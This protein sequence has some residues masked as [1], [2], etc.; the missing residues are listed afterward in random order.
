MGVTLTL[1]LLT[2]P[3]LAAI[4]KDGDVD[5]VWGQE[6]IE[7]DNATASGIPIKFSK[8][9]GAN[10][11]GRISGIDSFK[12]DGFQITLK[13]F[14]MP[15]DNSGFVI[16]LNNA[17]GGWVDSEGIYFLNFH[18]KNTPSLG[19]LSYGYVMAK[20]GNDLG[21][22]KP[23]II[24]ETKLNAYLDDT[25]T[26]EF[27]KTSSSQWTYTVNGQSFEFSD[28]IV[29]TMIKDPDNVYFSLGVWDTETDI[30][31]TIADIHNPAK[32]DTSPGSSANEN[33]ST[34]DSIIAAL[35]T[36]N[37]VP[38]ANE[39]EGS[40]SMWPVFVTA[41]LF[42]GCVAGGFFIIRNQKL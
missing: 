23:R 35:D 21:N 31:Y 4:P 11:T 8:A 34:S 12:M 13:N 42:T 39:K 25:V 5:N 1:S 20:E 7:V 2:T 27:K 16:G 15:K 3:A 26:I 37:H 38:A 30:S 19:D 9:D 6:G 24:S 29:S 36:S 14:T 10:W 40:H 18:K 41:L 17:P 22:A 33:N 32:A 28:S